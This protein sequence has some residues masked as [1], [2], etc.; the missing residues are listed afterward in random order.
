[1]GRLAAQTGQDAWAAHS[2]G[3]FEE[4]GKVVLVRHAPDHY[5][6]MLRAARDDVELASLEKVG[7]GVSHEALGAA[8][9]ESWGLAPQAVAS[10]R[11]HVEVHSTLELPP[12]VQRRAVCALSAI[13]HALMTAPETLEAVAEAVAPQA[14]L[15]VALM[16]RGTRKVDERLQAAVERAAA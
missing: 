2:A 12:Q 13:A 7:F 8:L 16:L 6:S 10:V 4:C 15:E 9:C 3:L 11:H 14:Q 1:M 5:P